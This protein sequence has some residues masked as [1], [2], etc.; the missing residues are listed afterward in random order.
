MQKPVIEVSTTISADPGTVWA[1][2]TRKKTAMF[3]DTELETD[4]EVGHPITLEGKHQGKPFT[5]HGEIRSLK[6]ERELSFSHWSGKEGSEQPES[7][8]VVRYKLEP[9]GEKTKVTLSQFNEGRDTELK[10]ETRLEFE[11]TWRMMLDGLKA[12]AE[13][14]D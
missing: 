12:S 13:A 1:A 10:A 7:Y 11:K 6:E 9:E 3:P 4:W 8:H 5:D 2:M 14:M